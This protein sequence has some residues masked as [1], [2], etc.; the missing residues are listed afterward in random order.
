MKNL[1]KIG[2]IS[3][4]I[5]AAS[6]IF[7]IGLFL[8]VLM[9]LADTNINIH[10]YMAFFVPH[11]TIVFVSTFSMYIIHGVCLVFLAL[12]LHERLRISSPTLS[13][14]ALCF[15]LIWSS[16]V[17]LSGFI[18]IWGNEALISLYSKSAAEADSLKTALS[19]ITLGIDSSDRFLG[20]L[21]IG[22]VC[23]A[24][25]KS[26]IFLKAFNWFGFIT[27]ILS[28]LIGLFLPANDSSASFLF[29]VSAII[30]WLAVG[31]YMIWKADIVS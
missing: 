5:S 13:V 31:F 18:N 23:F 3:A 30:W 25:F 24:S 22:F 6:Y 19:T 20:C 12:A 11:K 8:T 29:G 26:H 16:F 27:S 15:G 21:W 4:I 14:F 7:A 28:L 1:Q 17:L 2:G 9:P 10:D